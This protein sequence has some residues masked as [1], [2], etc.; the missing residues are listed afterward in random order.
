MSIAPDG[1]GVPGVGMRKVVDA[2]DVEG[3]GGVDDC[4]VDVLKL[5][6]AVLV[7]AALLELGFKERMGTPTKSPA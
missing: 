4:E 6:W 1:D 2:R 3:V 7:V 5:R